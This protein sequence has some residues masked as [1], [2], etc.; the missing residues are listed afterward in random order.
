MTFSLAAAASVGRLPADCRPTVGDRPVDRTGD[1]EQKGRGLIGNCV[2]Q[3]VWYRR[4]E[5]NPH[6]PLGTQRILRE[7]AGIWWAS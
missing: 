2:V 6:E 5:S 7:G 3:R 1:D 4:R